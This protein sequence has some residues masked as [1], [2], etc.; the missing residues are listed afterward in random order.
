MPCYEIDGL[1]PVVHPEA[2]IH[3]TAVLIGDVLVGPGCYV[4]PVCSLRGDFGRLVLEAGA[5]FQDT[6]VMHGFPDTDTVVEQ[7]GHIGHGAVLHGCIVR[8]NAMVG[9]NAVVM[10]KAVV[11]DSA[12]VAACAFVKAGMEIPPGVLVAGVPGKVVRELTEAE[13]AWKV[14]GTRQ[15]HELALRSRT[16]LRECQPLAAPDPG[17]ARLDFGGAVKPLMDTK[18]G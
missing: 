4:G 1:R 10:D 2:W 3:P 15:Y 8:R 9:M 16:T 11:G 13:R 6:C 17:R 7:D 5:N 18:R 14:A 12:I